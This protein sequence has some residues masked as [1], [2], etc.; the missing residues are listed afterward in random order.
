MCH[1]CVRGSSLNQGIIRLGMQ[2]GL[3]FLVI[4]MLPGHAA[5]SDKLKPPCSIEGTQ[6]D[7]A[8]DVRALNNYADAIAELLRQKKF[9]ELDC[10]A[11]SAR[12]S[13]ARFSGGA[14]K[15]RNA[16]IGLDSPR[17]TL[18]EEGWQEHFQLL[19]DWSKARPDSVTARIA[20]AESYFQYGWHALGSESD[21]KFSAERIQKART[22]LDAN[23]DLATKCPEWYLD[24]ELVAQEQDWD[25]KEERKLTEDAIA[26]EPEYQNLYR[27]HAHTLLPRRGGV[28]GDTERFLEASADK[29]GG[30]T[31]DALYFLVATSCTCFGEDIKQFSWPR[32]KRGFA[33]NERLHGPSLSNTNALAYLAFTFNDSVTAD[34]AFQ[35]IGDSWDQDIWRYEVRFTGTKALAAKQR[36]ED[37]EA[38]ANAR[39]PEGADYLQSVLQRLDPIERRCAAA[40]E[41][42][43][44]KGELLML[45]SWDGWM[46]RYRY[47]PANSSS[48]CIVRA[49]GGPYKIGG[50]PLPNPPHRS[51]WMAVEIDP[52]GT[53]TST[54]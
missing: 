48:D 34:D 22:I 1:F 41:A 44:G 32:L 51:Y 13:K 17:P 53:G 23:R 27:V 49:L 3:A 30:D 4:A 5:A 33:A 26:F 38:H 29:L 9:T 50:G 25:P 42:A 18:T 35:E 43:P 7:S 14:W 54:R 36:Q 10:I 16:Y 37:D 20:L 21:R 24:M 2:L 15:I 40:G 8:V 19:D 6:F 28:E 31:G 11:D 39:T 46:L 45:L 47:N 52:P 12:A